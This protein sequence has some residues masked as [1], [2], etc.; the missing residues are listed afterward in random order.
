M[1]GNPLRTRGLMYG[2]AGKSS[3]M[4]TFYEQAVGSSHLTSNKPCQDSGLAFS[5]DGVHIAIVCDGHGSESYVRS[6]VG[7]MLAA[8]VAK[9]EIIKFI[10]SGATKFIKGKRGKLLLCPQEIL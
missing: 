1:L 3:D 5:K 2:K 8:E 4:I 10:K 7:S 6:D 9:E